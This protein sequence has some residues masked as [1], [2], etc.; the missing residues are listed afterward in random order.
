MLTVDCISSV[1]GMKVTWHSMAPPFLFM[2]LTWLFKLKVAV[3]TVPHITVWQR[4]KL[5]LFHSSYSILSSG[6]KK[7]QWASECKLWLN[8]S[9]DFLTS[10]PLS[11]PVQMFP[12]S[13][14]A[15]AVLMYLPALI[16]RQLVMPSLGSDLLFIID[17]LDKSYNRSVRLAQSILD[18]RQNTKNPLTFQAELER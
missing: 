7:H 3:L 11:V 8:I 1:N 16:W 2:V 10:P 17:E 15:M 5:C 6:F 4:G 14:L 12:Y 13:L 18:M 9:S